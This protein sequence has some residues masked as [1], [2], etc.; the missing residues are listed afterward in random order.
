MI[1]IKS[2]S[3]AVNWGVGH[4]S[5]GWSNA[6]LLNA[7]N[8]FG[9][10]SYFASTAPTSTVFSIQDNTVTN[11]GSATYVAY[12]FAPVAGYSAFGSYTGNGDPNGTF[13]YLGFR[14]RFIMIKASSFST[15]STVWTI[16]DT[17]RSP[18]NASVL[19]LYPNDPISEQTDSNGIDI[20]SNGFKPRRNSEYANLSGQTY[21][22]MA[23]AE[24]PFKYANAR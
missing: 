6:G 12:C 20:L 9:S 15:A 23:F 2:K 8:S 3:N 16:F 7:P 24:H 1:I 21:I 17:R 13:V 11:I 14:P 10:S 4:V 5:A 22:Y 18:Y 19:E